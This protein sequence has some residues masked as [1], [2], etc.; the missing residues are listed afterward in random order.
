MS[1]RW[2]GLGAGLIFLAGYLFYARLLSRWFGL[3]DRHLTPAHRLRDG[4]DFV[5]TS[6]PVLFGHHFASIAGAGPIVGPILAASYG[7]LG[8]F[9]WLVLG[10]VLAGG[11]HDMG[12]MAASLRH[13][14][15]SIGELL[16]QYLGPSA[17]RLFLAFAVATLILVVAAFDVI[18]A[19]T[20][21]ASPPVATASL[22]FLILAVLFGLLYYRAGVPL[23]AITLF[24]LL[25]LA[26]SI[27]L[28]FRFPLHLKEPLWR[29]LLLGYVFLASVLPIWL[30]LQPRDYLNAFL[31]YALLLGALVGLFLKAPEVRL[32]VYTGFFN[33]LGPL[34]PLLFV[35]TSCGAI[36]GFHSL[37]ASG[38]TA[39]QADRESQARSVGYGAMLL[40]GVLGVV[41]LC[42]VIGFTL[43]DYQSLLK[44]KGPIAAFALGV[45][46]FLSAL[47]IPPE[48]GRAFAA[49]AVSAFALTSLDTATRVARFMVEEFFSPAGEHVSTA[50]SRTLFTLLVVAAAGGLAFS[51]AW[52]RIWPLMGAA[53]QLLAAL[54]LLALTVWLT[55]TGRFA[56]F[57]KIPALFMLAVTLTALVLLARKNFLSGKWLLAVLSLILLV[58]TLLLLR[59]AARKLFSSG[60]AQELV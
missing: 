54:A 3:D 45:G 33:D 20:F 29:A 17:Q 43:A 39:R 49:L 13:E 32:P 11:V 37:V 27:W 19:K 8:V 14:G 58:L 38:T 1:A 59:L 18:V 48:K 46:H 56:A 16:R 50:R 31:L 7:W 26:L 36:S 24:G 21:V 2:L 52:Q 5:P 57:V 44:A 42:A 10:A 30:L 25:G 47:G 22:G 28:G 60:K 55:S 41:S 23:P 53:N 4:L 6:T 51:G 40:E 15:R 35:I 9:L 12:S 34:F